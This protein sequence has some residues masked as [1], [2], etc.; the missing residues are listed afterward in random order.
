MTMGRVHGHQSLPDPMKAIS[1]IFNYWGYHEKY[2]Q[3]MCGHTV[4]TF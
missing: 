3:H 1:I 4:R 2:S